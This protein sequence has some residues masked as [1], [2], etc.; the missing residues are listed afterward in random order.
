M[1]HQYQP[2]SYYS[3]P[4]REHGIF[5]NNGDYEYVPYDYYAGD[6]IHNQNTIFRDSQ[7]VTYDNTHV[8]FINLSDIHVYD[9]SGIKIFDSGTLTLYTS[10]SPSAR[11]FVV[12]EY[13]RVGVG[14]DHLGPHSNVGESPSF[15]LDV[16]G[17]V[18][19][20]DYI[21]H[22]DD[23]DTYMLFGSDLSAHN[24]NVDGSI[25]T[26]YPDDQDEINFFT[27]D[28]AM[29]QMRTR[30]HVFPASNQYVNDLFATGVSIPEETWGISDAT[31]QTADIGPVPF[32]HTSEIV[33]SPTVDGH[34]V[35]RATITIPE[36]FN[37]CLENPDGCEYTV[38]YNIVLPGHEEDGTARSRTFTRAASVDP[39]DHVT[40][41]KYQ[42]DVDFVV[43][44][45]TNT[46]AF[47]VS[48]DGVEV[49]VNEDGNAD[50]DFRVESDHEDHMLFVDTS[51]NR[52]SIGDSEDTPQATLEVTND[53]DS[54]AFDVP[55]VQ[56]NNEDTDKQL[57]DINAKNIDA[58]VISVS[59]DDL[60]SADVVSVTADSLTTG[61][62]INATADSLTT[63]SLIHMTHTGSDKSEVSLVHF[64]ST[65]DRG[66]DSNQTVLL[67]LNFDT[68][69]GTGARALR[70]DTEQTTGKAF[71]LDAS[72]ITTG[73]GQ[74][75]NV[76]KMTTGEGLK[77]YAGARTTGTG[78][79]V[80]DVHTSDDPGALVLI[81]QAGD[82]T[83]AEASIGVDIDFNTTANPAA[84]ALRIDSEQTTGYVVEVDASEVTT[85]RALDITGVDSLTT[86]K[87]AYFGSNSSS[88]GG[89]NLVQIQNDNELATGTRALYI[90]NNAIASGSQE[91]V[92]IESTAADKNSLVELR[93]SNSAIDTPPVLNFK[94]TN[95][96]G[97]PSAHVDLGTLKFEGQAAP[98]SARVVYA[99]LSARATD[100]KTDEF[101]GQLNFMVQATDSPAQL[102]NMLS[103]GGQTNDDDGVETQAEVVIN[104]DQIDLD[105]RVET[106]ITNNAFIVYG[107][108]SEVVVNENGVDT[109]FRVEAH[110]LDPTQFTKD[111][112]SHDDTFETHYSA[113][114]THALY[115]NAE[116]G[117]VGIGHDT[118]QTT[119]HVAGSAHIEGDL[120]VKGVTNQI[121]TMV[122]V[123]S[124]MD[125]HNIGTGPTLTVTQSGAQPV[126]TFWDMDHTDTLQPALYLADKTMAGFGTI[127]TAPLHL[128]DTVQNKTNTNPLATFLLDHNYDHGG[129][130]MDSTR[131]DKQTHIRWAAAG[132]LKWQIRNK[133]QYSGCEAGELGIYSFEYDGGQDV[134]TFNH[135]GNVGIGVN[136][137]GSKLQVERSDGISI[138]DPTDTNPPNVDNTTLGLHNIYTGGTKAGTYSNIQFVVNGG[139]NC[140]GTIALV[141]EENGSGKG[142]LVFASDPGH[143]T[144]KERVRIK[145]DGNVG[146]NVTDPQYLLDVFA[147]ESYT[148]ET[149]VKITRDTRTLQNGSNFYKGA[150]IDMRNHN[151]PGN[152][153]DGG[154]RIALDASSY[155]SDVSFAGDLDTQMGVWARTGTYSSDPTGHIETTY[156]VQA[157]N[158]RSVNTTITEQY[159]FYQTSTL[160]TGVDV[161]EVSNYFEGPLRIGGSSMND[162]HAKLSVRSDK[163][164]S[165]QRALE[166]EGPDPN[167]WFAD[168]TSSNGGHD[169]DYCIKWN[170]DYGTSGVLGFH[171]NQDWSPFDSAKM[172]HMAID[173][174]TGKVGIGTDKP[175]W[176]LDVR[177]EDTSVQIQLGRI[178]RTDT[179]TS[180]TAW[181]GADDQ[182]FHLGWGTYGS[183]G[184]SVEQPNGMLIDKHGNMGLNSN[185][186]RM[187]DGA[188]I[189][190]P[191]GFDQ[192]AP[193]LEIQSIDTTTALLRV[194]HSTNGSQ[195]TGAIEV[196]QDA[197]NGG[198]ICYNGDSNPRFIANEVTDAVVYYRSKSTAGAL[199]N[200]GSPTGGTYVDRQAVFYY[201]YNSNDVTFL[202]NIGLKNDAPCLTLTDT[203]GASSTW[204]TSS[205]CSDSSTGDLVLTA[206]QTN[207]KANTIMSFRLDGQANTNERMRVESTGININRPVDIRNSSSGAAATLTGSVHEGTTQVNAGRIGFALYDANSHV[208][209]TTTA[210]YMYFETRTAL[211]TSGPT[212]KMRLT[213]AGDLGIGVN[214]PSTRLHV[215]DKVGTN[216]ARTHKQSILTIQADY[217]GTDGAPYSGFGG[218]IVFRNETYN[219]SYYKSAGIYGGI[220]DNSTATAVGGHLAFHTAST[221]T[222]DPTEKVRIDPDGNVGINTNT[223]RCALDINDTDA[224]R[225]PAGTTGERPTA[226]TGMIR[227]NSTLS[228]FE[229]YG[230]NAWGSLG[231][232]VDTDKDTY[233]T[234]ESG[235]DNDQL[236]FYTKG[237]K[238]MTISSAGLV[239]IGT[240]GTI[241]TSI[242]ATTFELSV[243]GNIRADGDVVAF[244]TSDAR[245]KDNVKRIADPIDKIKA[246]G[247]YHFDWNDK[248]QYTGHDV[249][250]LAQEVEQ[251]LPEVVKTRDNGDK[252]VNYEKIVPLLIECINSQSR[253]I[254]SMKNQSNSH[255]EQLSSSEKAN[256]AKITKME[257]EINRLHGEVSKIT[258]LLE[259]WVKGE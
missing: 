103:I 14:M 191:S 211:S 27:G 144:R 174:E 63:G 109:D 225:I 94:V 31:I 190:H 9:T 101:G 166:V 256:Q 187:R 241:D 51:V 81:E 52:I 110:G 119:L 44:S 78:L 1:S 242:Q 86:G 243:G 21:Y 248:S 122:H 26:I 247:G 252:A 201:M 178:G 96:A 42:S 79:N 155:I 99:A 16:K 4:D 116:N 72:E 75:I 173:A 210:G 235:N 219:L 41:N 141:A 257:K 105:F 70:I 34:R 180:G 227:Y 163:S 240:L 188:D 56:L 164:A 157:N 209:D 91:T 214:S 177:D 87:I 146:I 202:G 200:T 245:L 11:K 165:T 17:Q 207:K 6:E 212:E 161:D 93:N 62:V 57:L 74:L 124:S 199:S 205:V 107:D 37:T 49:V 251:V 12:D 30:D 137:P 25:N 77:I 160:P 117:R 220:G 204:H 145:S 185:V 111:D 226:A 195:G 84:R 250:V 97:S 92:R 156:A 43:R 129:I 76:A 10:A 123:T 217:G 147:Q 162:Q 135:S 215:Y 222:A 184:G 171:R 216:G 73:Q 150:Y 113:K 65:G 238:R 28:I 35:Y 182:S 115:V 169:D 168:S 82:R 143:N 234:P 114:K 158:L 131:G 102:R 24:V 213:A 230:A 71:E 29:L 47:V 181:M 60:V 3:W 136:C 208:S 255:I 203:T 126:A 167:I 2:T 20:E 148:R 149:G 133:L 55:L 159:G 59:A 198:G 193:I 22:N 232:V 50:T 58:D 90:K 231:G 83:G 170:G 8:R 68:T 104:E 140:V 39:Q 106:D 66:D 64:E 23:V 38:N 15:D 69:D 253:T 112:G 127:P 246:I 95:Y 130:V 61:D 244:A 236:E 196:T 5:L 154:Y 120:W 221:K 223:P 197:F 176:A 7:Y 206:D 80:R 118:P 153:N 229:G 33:D 218:G 45:E 175:D 254:T 132:D 54:G 192:P 108:G 121:D 32:E 189:N 46:G 100:M 13:G 125:I 259:G 224:I 134:M 237:V 88:T 151:S 152:I 233:I 249:G 36:E 18:G 194:G 186:A 183:D 228:T 19:I 142:S 172:P 128:S 53:P 67:D 139:E 98:N 179:T 85:G 40:V 239:Q 258:T 138:Y 89:R 48:G